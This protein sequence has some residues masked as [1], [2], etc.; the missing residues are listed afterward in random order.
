LENEFLLEM[1][2][3][4]KEFNGNQVLKDVNI[5]VR[6]GEIVALCGENGAGKSTLMNILFGMPVI[7]QT[8]GFKGEVLINGEPVVIADPKQAMEHGIG[9]VHQ[10]F[11]LIDGFNV[12]ENIKLNRENLKKT[13]VSYVFGNRLSLLDRR[14]MHREAQGI[15]KSLN[16]DLDENTRVGSLSVGYKQFIEISR[17]LDKKNIKLIVLD[18]PTAVLTETEAACFIECVRNVAKR[19]ISFIFISHRLDEVKNL[20]DHVFILRDGEE[21]GD[22]PINELSIIQI[23]KLMVGRE[24]SMTT[25]DLEKDAEGQGDVCL[26]AEHLSVN[27]V[28]E[29]THD[30]SFSVKKGEILG[31]GGLAGHGKISIANGIIGLCQSAGVV[32][33]NGQV[34]DMSDTEKTLG[35]GVA[36][37]SEDRRGVGLALDESIE[38]NIIIGAMRLQNR[39]TKRLCGVDFFDQKAASSY[40]ERLIKELDIRCTGRKQRVGRLSGG[41]QQKVCIARAFTQGSNILFISE[42]TRGIDIGAKK[43]ILDSLLRLNKEEGGTII[44][45]SSELAELRSICNRIA[46]VTDGKIAGILKPTD[47]D[48]K[49]GLLM[50][51]VHLESEE[52]GGR[53]NDQVKA[54]D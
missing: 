2:H 30:I 42:P 26:E 31:I 20:S 53:N 7:H 33:I 40:V 39:F 18:E 34:I 44:V 14:A 38:L 17:E 16:I 29:V 41:N 12:A 6:P 1:N 11:M 32:K 3:I 19:G 4:S 50:S 48:Y 52:N 27:M 47:D 9:M 21:V 10:E 8:G 13:A 54:S 23:S 51:G 25:R 36:F 22:Y 24:V 37:V 43:M 15:L 49:F 5:R 28:G 45:T 35:M 46:I